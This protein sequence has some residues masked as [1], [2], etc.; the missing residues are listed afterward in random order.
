MKHTYDIYRH[1][2]AALL[3]LVGSQSLS[4]QDAFY[5]YRNDGEF[6]GFFYDDIVRMGVSK[7]DLDSIEHEE[8]VVQDIE[9]ADSIYRIPLAAIDSIG[10]QQPEIVLNPKAKDIG[11]QGL[12][13]Y[14]KDFYAYDDMTVFFRPNWCLKKVMCSSTSQTQE[15]VTLCSRRKTSLDLPAK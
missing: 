7:Y 4:A 9:T 11:A 5:V 6:N 3:L 10:F 8:Y 13:D 1:L 15:S 12:Y 2:L 14:M